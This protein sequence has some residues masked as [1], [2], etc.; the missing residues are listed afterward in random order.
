MIHHKTDQGFHGR[1]EFGYQIW[2]VVGDVEHQLESLD[3]RHIY[4]GRSLRF[5]TAGF[6]RERF[7][8]SS[9][10]VVDAVRYLVLYDE[11]LKVDSCVVS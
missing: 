5:P 2:I 6:G 11:F 4:H 9:Y 3:E 7:G 8:V 10:C 1:C